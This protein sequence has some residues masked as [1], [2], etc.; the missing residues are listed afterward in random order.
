MVKIKEIV[1]KV[2]FL[3]QVFFLPHKSLN[4]QKS[5]FRSICFYLRHSKFSTQ[6]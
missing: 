4:F 6:F 2:I 5:T 1:R 3:S